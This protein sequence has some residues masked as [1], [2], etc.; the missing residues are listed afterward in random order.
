[1]ISIDNLSVEKDSKTILNNINITFTT[2]IH[3]VLGRNGSGKTTLLKVIAGVVK[4]SKGNV[5]VFG[6]NIHKLPR[7]EAVKLVGYAWQNPYAG[8]LEPTVE[9]EFTLTEKISK[10]EVDWS[11]IRIL[12]P[13]E[14]LNR[15]PFTL[16]GG[17]AKR[18]ATAIALS[19]NQPVWLLDEPFDF[20]DKD[21]VEAVLK[22][23][24]VAKERKKVVVVATSNLAYLHLLE[25][26]SVTVIDG[27]KIVKELNNLPDRWLMCGCT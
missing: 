13:T 5:Y 17:E 11:I 1:M 2:G 3:F 6:K 9:G 15:N 4:P 12:V 27:G 16:S 14:Y 25:P 8:F 19:L 23:L 7:K 10:S 18:V 22:L 21:G 24:E 26:V 20:L